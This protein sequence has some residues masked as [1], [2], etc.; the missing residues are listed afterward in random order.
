MTSKPNCSKR[1]TAETEGGYG[2]QVHGVPDFTGR[3]GQKCG[4]DLLFL[5]SA[6]VIGHADHGNTAVT[7]LDGDGCRFRVDGIFH[8][9]FY[10]RCR[11]FNDLA[12]RDLVDR[13]G[14]QKTN[15]RHDFFLSVSYSTGF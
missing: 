6:A 15:L 12:R 9:F 11:S 4:M 1:L 3:M 14:I 8:Q 13:I 5:D 7:D 2:D 10:N